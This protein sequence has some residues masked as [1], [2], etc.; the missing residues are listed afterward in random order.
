MKKY[1]NITDFPD[2]PKCKCI[3]YP[4]YFY[5]IRIA[6]GKSVRLKDVSFFYCPICGH[7]ELPEDDRYMVEV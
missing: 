4:S 7:K 5:F 6:H 2:C 3:L 1:N